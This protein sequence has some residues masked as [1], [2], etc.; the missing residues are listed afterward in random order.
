MNDEVICSEKSLFTSWRE[1]ILYQISWP[2][3]VLE[4][5][6]PKHQ[7]QTQNLQRSVGNHNLFSQTRWKLFWLKSNVYL[8]IIK[9]KSTTEEWWFEKVLQQLQLL[10]RLYPPSKFGTFLAFNSLFQVKSSL[11]LRERATDSNNLFLD[12]SKLKT[13]VEKWFF[14]K[15]CNFI[16]LWFWWKKNMTVF[17]KKYVS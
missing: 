10:S 2:I 4:N 12:T 13:L 5:V 16:L 6:W 14:L 17:T 1:F 11:S 3:E 8:R 7:S 15:N 9:K